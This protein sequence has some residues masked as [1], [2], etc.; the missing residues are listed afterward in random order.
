MLEKGAFFARHYGAGKRPPFPEAAV[1]RPPRV[2][3]QNGIGAFQ[4]IDKVAPISGL[5]YHDCRGPPP[6][7]V[8]F[9]I[10]FLV[11]SSPVTRLKQLLTRG[12]SKYF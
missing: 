3:H 2:D 10:V 1:K 12:P 8:S 9:V 6:N 4:D 7:T 11:E 5:K